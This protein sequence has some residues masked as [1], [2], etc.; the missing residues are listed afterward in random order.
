MYRS[1][2]RNVGHFSGFGEKG[3]R[4]ALFMP[5]QLNRFEVGYVLYPTAAMC[6][7]ILFVTAIGGTECR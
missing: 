5:I 4:I 6:R 1:I 2:S 7:I 3:V